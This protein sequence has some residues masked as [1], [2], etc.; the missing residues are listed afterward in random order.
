MSIEK[1]PSTARPA[2]PVPADFAHQRADIL[3]FTDLDFQ[4]HVNN[5]VITTFFA[6]ARFDFLGSI[7]KHLEQGAK[8]VIARLEVDFT[9]EVVFSTTP[10][11]TGTR[12][13]SF[14]RTSMRLEQAL[15]QDGRCA[16]RAVCVFVHKTA[17]ASAPWPDAVLAL[18][19]A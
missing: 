17:G 4:Q 13:L 15:F 6:N 5:A 16:A 9:D 19:P 12:V 3:R 1:Q 10:V 7:R 18:A 11:Q 2:L 14:G 8:L